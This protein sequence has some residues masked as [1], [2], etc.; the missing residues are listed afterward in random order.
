MLAFTS[1]L[2]ALNNSKTQIQLL[3]SAI[4][5]VHTLFHSHRNQM[6]FAQ[7]GLIVLDKFNDNYDQVSHYSSVPR[8]YLHQYYSANTVSSCS[9]Q[10]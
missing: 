4:P 8:Q 6:H 3:R 2:P 9:T 10:H 5:L 1:L 7:K